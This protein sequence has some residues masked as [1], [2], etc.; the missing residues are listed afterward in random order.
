M[1]KNINELYN[2]FDDT[3]IILFLRNQ[4][5][6]ASPIKIYSM[7]K[8]YKKYSKKILQKYFEQNLLDVI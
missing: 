2:M 7:G 4:A 1:K 3:K 8:D 5:H 6:L